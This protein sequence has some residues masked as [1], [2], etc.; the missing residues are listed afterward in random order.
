MGRYL[1][2]TS[3]TCQFI[4]LGF[5][6]NGTRSYLPFILSIKQIDSQVVTSLCV[7]ASERQR[8][9]CTNNGASARRSDTRNNDGNINPALGNFPV[10]KL[11][12]PRECTVISE[13]IPFSV[14]TRSPV[15]YLTFQSDGVNSPAVSFPSKVLEM[16]VHDFC[17]LPTGGD[18]NTSL[19]FPSLLDISSSGD[20]GEDPFSRISAHS[21]EINAI[22]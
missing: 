8:G 6:V 13:A 11:S 4:S 3:T 14:A 7:S 15:Y 9:L 18:E 19:T 22:N 16:K 5:V 2:N 20:E 1:L 12:A 17:P 10:V 21:Y